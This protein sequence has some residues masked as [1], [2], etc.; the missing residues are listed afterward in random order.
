M[1]F[2]KLLFASFICFGAFGMGI[3]FFLIHEPWVDFSILQ[4]YNPGKPTILLDDESNEWARFQLDK[5]EPISRAQMP[6]TLINAFIAAEDHDFFKHA[7]I[8]FR[9][10][11]RS[12][13]VNIK[14]RRIVQ[15]A[16]TITQQL[17]K[18]LFY[19]NERTFTRKLKEQ[20]LAIIVEMQFTKE[21]ILEVYLNHVYF[22]CGIYGIEAASQQF[23]QKS[24]RELTLTEAATLAAIVRSPG[25]YCPLINPAKTIKRRNIVLHSLFKLGFITKLQ[26]EKGCNE[27]L[28]I[29]ASGLSASSAHMKEW[30]RQKLEALLGKDAVYSG[31]FTVQT[32]LHYHAQQAAYKVFTHHIRTIRTNLKQ[33]L[34]GALIS[35]DAH[36]G[37]IKALVGGYDFTTSKFNRAVQARRQIGSIIKPFIFA[38][39]LKKGAK[40]TDVYIDEPLT[41]MQGNQP[42][43]PR[44]V[45]RQF[46]GSMTL[47]H[48]LSKSNNIIPIKLLL[49]VG[50][51][52]LIELLRLCAISGNI[53]AYPSL[54]LGCCE[55]T[56]LE[57]VSMFNIFS[58]NGVFVEPYCI[59]WIKDNWGTKI[60]RHTSESRQILGWSIASQIVS[61]LKIRMD[62][63]KQ[64]LGDKWLDAETIGK[65]G[66]TNNARTCSFVGST[67]EVTTVVYLGCDDNSPLHNIFASTTAFPIWF[68][69]HKMLPNHNKNFLYEPHLMQVTVDAKT[70]EF[71]YS[72][73]PYAINLLTN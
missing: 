50:F 68:D 60:W 39:A 71:C 44:N 51:E 8:S 23:W 49:Q 22:G 43:T 2:L 12:F 52:P 29:V 33:Q 17:V 7:G 54:A 11:L 59:E 70:G 37:A 3:F 13:F 45:S 18:L 15:G 25:H 4:N 34:D 35:I 14:N 58:N 30:L 20:F 66:T 46:E 72:D 67:P 69:Y 63:L 6:Q 28:D 48:A 47:A 38:L 26:Y 1:R 62:R 61:A 56:P 64:Q 32:T 57:V 42:W 24:A 53:P 73:N 55:A 40:L 5:R 31:G 19:S 9:G 21:Q 41:L 10:I 65:T 27:P 36:T 16:S